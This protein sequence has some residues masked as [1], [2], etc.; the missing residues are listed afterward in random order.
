MDKWFSVNTGNRNLSC[1][2][3]HDV[4]NFGFEQWKKH[5][6]VSSENYIFEIWNESGLKCDSKCLV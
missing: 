2:N 4:K 5:M 1:F 6:V 3:Q